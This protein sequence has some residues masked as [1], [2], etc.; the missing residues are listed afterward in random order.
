MHPLPLEVPIGLVVRYDVAVANDGNLYTP[1]NAVDQA[2]VRRR[3]VPVGFRVQGSGF[4]VQ[5]SGF[6]FPCAVQDFGLNAEMEVR[7]LV[8]RER[9]SIGQCVCLCA[10]VFLCFCVCV[11]TCVLVQGKKFGLGVLGCSASVRTYVELRCTPQ[12]ATLPVLACHPIAT[13]P[14]GRS[15]ARGRSGWS[16][17]GR[18]RGGRGPSGSHRRRRARRRG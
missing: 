5:G 4:R 8:P 13:S 7:G 17:E 12:G 6:R 14:Q 15:S 1:R 16:M 3:M 2:P 9:E 11:C 18:G 10:C